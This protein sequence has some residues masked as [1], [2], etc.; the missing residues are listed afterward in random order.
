MLKVIEFKI[1][2]KEPFL[3]VKDEFLLFL[4]VDDIQVMAR[5]KRL[6]SP[7]TL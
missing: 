5:S 6:E 1:Y 7:R 2:T 3:L 4:F